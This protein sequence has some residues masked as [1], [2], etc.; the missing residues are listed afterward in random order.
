MAIKRRWE[1]DTI[2]FDNPLFLCAAAD[3]CFLAL[4]GVPRTVKDEIV[5]EMISSC[6]VVKQQ[7]SPS[8]PHSPTKQ[9]SATRSAMSILLCSNEED[10]NEEAEQERSAEEEVK[11]YFAGKPPFKDSNSLAWWKANCQRFSRMAK[12]ARHMLAIPATS[13]SSER[14][15][16]A[17]GRTVTKLRSSLKPENV[18]SVLYLN[19]NM[20]LYNNLSL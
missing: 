18:Q 6:S 10:G 12:V 2:E 19:K 7:A 8:S 9:K 14:L 13:A 4:K 11:A 17:A 3:P 20:D 5:E 1:L 15:F 16:S